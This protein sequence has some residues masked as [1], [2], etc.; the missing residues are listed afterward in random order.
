MAI[1]HQFQNGTTN[2]SDL[3]S[4]VM[5]NTSYDQHMT[6]YIDPD[7][8][9]RSITAVEARTTVK[10]LIAG[11]K[12]HGLK[13]GDCVCMHAYNDVSRWPVAGITPVLQLSF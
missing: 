4:W 11:L 5:R 1:D 3:V 13:K 6:L 9:T 7:H 10:Q 12:A 8:P 2:G